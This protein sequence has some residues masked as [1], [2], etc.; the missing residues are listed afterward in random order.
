MAKGSI[1]KRKS[2]NYAIVYYIDGK[3]RWKNISKIKKEAER[4][5][6][7]IMG[8]IDRGEYREVPNITFSELAKKWLD[9]K[10]GQVR[11]KTFASYKPHAERLNS[12]FGQHRVKNISQEIVESFAAK[13]GEREDI[14]PATVSRCL[15]IASSIFRKG[16][17][18]GYLTRNP[19]EFVKKP[20][21]P[22]PEM[23]F[24]MP[25]EIKKLIE[26]TDERYRTLI[27][28]ACLTGCRQSE[29]LGLRWSDVDFE[30]G[31][32]FIRQTLQGGAFYEPKSEKSKRA[33]VIP[34]VLV[35]A[36]KVHQ[37]RQM[38]E[39]EGNPYD[40]VFP[41]SVGKPM[42]GRNLT[43]RVLEPALRVAGI[44]KVGFHAL[45]HSYVSMLVNGGEN[46]KFIQKQVGHSSAQ[47]TWDIYSHLFP[48][49]EREAVLRLEKVLFDSQEPVAE[50]SST[51]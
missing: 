16:I 17:Q 40:L 4:A 2:G 46:I 49:S 22:K 8:E 51:G 24:L 26:A 25:E 14:A 21:V 7:A 5:L 33:V 13:L 20:K 34:P 27:M 41:N 42:G 30:S 48:E 47:V 6:R 9:L 23:D 3:Q 44:R 37:L 19:A 39:L 10:Q 28:F 50:P 12:A 32:V 1:V 15:T 45:R 36:L 38:T 11:P 31:R 35:E 43:L 29:I 18:W